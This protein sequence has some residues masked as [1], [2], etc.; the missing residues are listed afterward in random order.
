MS[1]YETAF[2]DQLRD[3]FESFKEDIDRR[4]GRMQTFLLTVLTVLLSAGLVV[5]FTHFTRDGETRTI[6]TSN[7]E[8]VEYIMEN[9]VS[10]KAITDILTTFDNNTKAMEQFL[11]EDIQGY[12]KAT[13]ELNRNFRSYIMTFQS[14]LNM[15]GGATQEA[16][17]KGGT[18]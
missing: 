11:P 12:V 7:T 14:G 18:Q 9:A 17:Q 6:L 2:I 5:G 4:Y 13:N 8:K 1:E 3:E 16:D 10:Q 15:R